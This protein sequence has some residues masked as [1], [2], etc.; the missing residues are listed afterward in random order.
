MTGSDA[1]RELKILIVVTS[2]NQAAY[3]EKTLLSI[4]EQNYTNKEII[5][6]DDGSTDEGY[7]VGKKLAA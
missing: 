5:V 3:L 2:Y 7:S 1:K 4:I 6:I